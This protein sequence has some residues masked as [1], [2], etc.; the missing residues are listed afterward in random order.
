MKRRGFTL[1]EILVTAAL[2]GFVGLA[3]HAVTKASQDA[4]SANDTQTQAMTSAQWFLYHLR[5]ELKQ[6]SQ[7]GLI[8]ACPAGPGQCPPNPWQLTFN[9]KDAGNPATL[10]YTR[11]AANQFLRQVGAGAPAPVGGGGVTDFT[12]TCNAN[13][14]VGLSVTAQAVAPG[15]RVFTFT[16]SSQFWV[17][18]P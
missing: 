13:G 6:A 7:T 4:W 16:A 1:V 5:S 12:P 11:D 8:C 3:L 2:F 18:N 9:G 14:L 10:T 15:G 17:A